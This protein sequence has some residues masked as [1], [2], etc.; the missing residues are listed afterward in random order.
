VKSKQG[1]RD[2][3]PSEYRQASVQPSQDRSGP[4]NLVHIKIYTGSIY[5]LYWLDVSVCI[6]TLMI[7]VWHVLR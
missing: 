4:E 2:G 6:S 7:M 5:H 3:V 1:V